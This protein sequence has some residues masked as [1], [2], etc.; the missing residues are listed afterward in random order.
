[1]SYSRWS[2][3]D[4]YTFYSNSGTLECCGCWLND[5]SQSFDSVTGF[6]DH[7]REHVAAGHDLDFDEIMA[8]IREDY[9]AGHLEDVAP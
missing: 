4:V 2:H 7:L 8:R 6:E 1:M 3:S 5:T 9:D